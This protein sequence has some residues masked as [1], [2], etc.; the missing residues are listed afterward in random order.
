MVKRVDKRIKSIKVYVGGK[1]SEVLEKL[2]ALGGHWAR[3]SDAKKVDESPFLIS[4]MFGQILHFGNMKTFEHLTSL[5]EVSAEELI[6][7]EPVR[8]FDP[9]DRVL[10]R[11]ADDEFWQIDLYD[12]YDA[13]DEYSHVCLRNR[14]RQCISF[15]ENKKLQGAIGKQEEACS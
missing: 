6:G 1:G 13:D 4:D 5:R 8:V 9:F 12:H 15:E 10:V 11:D 14:W 2:I 7:M 3:E